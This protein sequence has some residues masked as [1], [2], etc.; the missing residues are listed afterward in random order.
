MVWFQGHKAEFKDLTNLKKLFLSRYNPWGKTKR[1][2]LQSWDNLLFDPQKT[3]VDEQIDLVFT[4]RDMLGQEEGAKVDKFIKTMPTSIQPH[5]VTEK[6]WADVR[7]KAKELEHIIHKCD[8]LVTASTS[9]QA[10]AVPSL[11][12]HIAQ[13]DDHNANDIPK[14]FKSSKGRG[15]KKSGKGKQKQQ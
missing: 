11:Y 8:P 12:L 9:M 3:D 7:K 15:G 4:L 1:V 14:P 13:S 2:Q 6:T 5:L 10:A